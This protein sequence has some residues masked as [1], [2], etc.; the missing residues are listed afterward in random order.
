MTA[1]CLPCLALA[2]QQAVVSTNTTEDIST[3][4]AE[5]SGAQRAAQHSPIGPQPGVDIGLYIFVAVSMIIASSSGFG[6]GKQI[7]NSSSVSFEWLHLYCTDWGY[8]NRQ[9]LPVSAAVAAVK[10]QLKH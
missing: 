10:R 9:Q 6:G 3:S 1:L 2:Q 5:S 8:S 7:G 4:S